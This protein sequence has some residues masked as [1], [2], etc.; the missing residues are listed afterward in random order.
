M[1]KL[2]LANDEHVEHQELGCLTQEICSLWF[3]SGFETS[4]LYLYLSAT[5]VYV[6]M[7]SHLRQNGGVPVY[8]NNNKFSNMVTIIHCVSLF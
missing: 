8:P 2:L 1:K 3:N 7:M 5:C 6:H 4:D